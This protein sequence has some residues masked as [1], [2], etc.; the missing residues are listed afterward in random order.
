M[1]KSFLISCTMIGVFGILFLSMFTSVATSAVLK[2]QA[3]VK[4][5]QVIVVGD[6]SPSAIK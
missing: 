5:E 1:N 3:K 6:N 4:A 2:Q